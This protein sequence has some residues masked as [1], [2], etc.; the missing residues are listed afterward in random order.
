MKKQIFPKETLWKLSSESGIDF[1]FMNSRDGFKAFKSH[2]HDC[3]ELIYVAEGS[4]HITLDDTNKTVSEG[5]L[6]IISP[7]QVH[8]GIPHED[9]VKI[10]SFFLDLE[11]L[12][13]KTYITSQFIK[14][15]IE[16]DFIFTSTTNHPKIIHKLFEII[17]AP[18][19]YHPIC[20]QGMYFELIGLLFEYAFVS[21]KK[22]STIKIKNILTYIHEHLSEDLSP[23]NI[24]E[25][26][27]YSE[28]HLCRMF[29]NQ[30]GVTVC[31]YIQN[32]RIENAKTLL[33]E[34]NMEIRQI[35]ET[36]GFTD[37]SY[38]CRLFK[39][40]TNSSPSQF[41]KN[42]TSPKH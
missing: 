23:K 17:H 26:F 39:A 36:C 9:G 8:A 38:F 13:N 14:P 16:G 32:L 4:I 34:T 24:S 3:M 40:S 12:S 15:L 7:K 2:W 10:Y 25:F 37:F 5:E 20:I 28:S 30:I 19:N 1:R 27:S 22:S 18:K 33:L 11:T 21:Q 41:R 31:K 42:Y 6:I 29:K 35:S